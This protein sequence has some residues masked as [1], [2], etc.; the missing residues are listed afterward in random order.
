MACV[1]RTVS[2]PAV[3]VHARVTQIDLLAQDRKKIHE[4]KREIKFAKIKT[5][6]R[7]VWPLRNVKRMNLERREVLY[8]HKSYPK[9]RALD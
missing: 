1:Y 5:E 8:G 9:K 2:E 6:G 7:K 4:W 3:H